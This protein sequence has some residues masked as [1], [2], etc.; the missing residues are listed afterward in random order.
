MIFI[1]LDDSMFLWLK[2]M[3]IYL[4]IPLT[5]HFQIEDAKLIAVSLFV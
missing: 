3:Y 5:V 2:D 4:F 1:L